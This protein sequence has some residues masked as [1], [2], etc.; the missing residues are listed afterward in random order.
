MS[1][2]GLGQKRDGNLCCSKKEIDLHL[3]STY[4]DPCR[5]EDLGQYDILVEPPPPTKDFNTKEPLLKEVQ[6][7]VKKA[8]ASSAPGP[9][10]APY[11]VYKN[12]PLLLKRLWKMLRVIWRR[13]KV[14]QQWKFAEGVWI[15]KE[16]DSKKIDQFRII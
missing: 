11:K 15:S 13:G 10:G 5:Q 9:S 7:V 12:C 4:S 16:K 3:H 1:P 6:E 14:A 2:K 8:R